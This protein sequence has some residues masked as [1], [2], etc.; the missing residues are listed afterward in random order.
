MIVHLDLFDLVNISILF[1]FFCFLATIYFKFLIEKKHIE[2]YRNGYKKGV[3]D[4]NNLF[5]TF[6][7]N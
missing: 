7:E 1:V 5:K 6:S 3:E 2:G 4:M